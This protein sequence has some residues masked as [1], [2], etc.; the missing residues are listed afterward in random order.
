MTQSAARM[1]VVGSMG[2]L[3]ANLKCVALADSR[4]QRASILIAAIP[5]AP[6]LLEYSSCRVSARREPRPFIETQER[7]PQRAG[8]QPDA[9]H[10][11]CLVAH[12]GAARNAVSSMRMSGG[13]RYGGHLGRASVMGDRM[14]PSL[15]DAR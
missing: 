12:R 2:G 6:A 13:E 1:Q 15:R 11:A 3:V 9:G 14:G 5:G 8:A 4:S 7:R 10:F